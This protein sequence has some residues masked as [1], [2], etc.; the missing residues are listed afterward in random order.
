MTRVNGK[1]SE[2][3]I[4]LAVKAVKVDKISKKQVAKLHGIPDRRLIYYL[5]KM[6]NSG[7]L[8]VERRKRT[9]T[10]LSEN[11]EEELGNDSDDGGQFVRVISKSGA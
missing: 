11:Q 9:P 2:L 6:D 1:W 3:Q 7:D 5:R 8:R 4:K 10:T